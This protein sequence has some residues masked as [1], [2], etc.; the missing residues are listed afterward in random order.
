MK[1]KLIY[2]FIA[3]AAAI[4]PAHAQKFLNDELTLSNVSLWQ[5]G[6][7]LYVGMTFDMSKLTIGST[8]SLSLIPLLTDG[9]HNV[10]LQEIIVNGKRREKAYIRGLAITKQEPTALIVPY[11]K[12]ETFNYTQIIP[13]K[14]WMS[15]AS[16]QL[17]ENLCGCGNYQEMN[18]QELITN[19][20]STEAKRLSAMSPF[21][22]YI[23]PTVEV[24]KNRS[25]QYEAHLDFPV[26]KII[27]YPEYRRNTSELA[28]IRATIDTV[29]ND[30]YTTLT[31]IKIH[32]YAS[33]EGS[34]A[35]NTRL[36]KNRTQALVDYVTSYYNF[37]KKLITSEYTPEDWK[38]FRKF[39]SAS[40][41]E[42]KEEVLR[43]IDDESINIDKKER[44]I[45]NLVGPQTYQYIL[46]ECYPALRHS[47]YTVNYTVRGLSLEE[48]KEIINKRPQLLSLQ[49]IYRIA[50]SCEPGSEEFNHSF[51]VAATMFPDDPIAN[52]NA[53]AMEIQKGG[54]MT[55]AKRYL[56]KADP[57][58]AETQNNLGIIAMIEGDLDTAEKYFNAAK[59][60][61]LIKQADAN[62]KELK[63]K[64]NYPLE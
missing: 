51:Q 39:V 28:K 47:D 25:E 53:G 45:A 58:A 31:R 23:Q 54:D 32:G 13:Y 26:N 33:P 20:V 52:L 22:A 61:G 59:A 21:V 38:G 12:R 11:N 16:L 49:E 10:P 1:R 7:S 50:E 4:L 60:A 27:I 40:S 37:D 3:F 19:D 44:D 64:Q 15:N 55:T 36:A 18:A 17:V 48:S 2:L 30:K 63:K 57:K 46:A 56:A 35:N 14:P 34:Y 41:I 9:Q 24:V 29:R 8:R 62:L 43:L 6:N 42:K 5:Q